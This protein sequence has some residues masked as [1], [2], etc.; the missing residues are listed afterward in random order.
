MSLPLALYYL[1]LQSLQFVQASPISPLNRRDAS[2]C[3]E[4]QDTR[5]ISSIIWSCLATVFL[6]TWVAIHPN[7]PPPEKSIVT[8]LRRVGI[9]AMAVI[10][11]ELVIMWAM[12]QWLVSRKLRKKYENMGW[13]QTH[14]FFALMGGFMLYEGDQPIRT[15][16]PDELEL[17]FLAGQIDFPH[18]TEEEIKD[19]SKGD[20][21]SKGLVIV[22]TGWFIMQCVARGVEHLPI[23]KLELSTLAFAVLNLATYALWW[24]KPLNVKRPFRVYQDK[25]SDTQSILLYGES[26]SESEGGRQPSVV[27][28]ILG[29]ITAP[30][31]PFAHMA[32]P[33]D[34]RPGAKT[35]P[36]FYAGS[37][38]KSELWMVILAAGTVAIAFGAIHCVAWSFQFPSHTERLIWRVSSFIIM[39]LPVAILVLHTDHR[40]HETPLILQAGA[41]ETPVRH[42]VNAAV[43][44][45]ITY[46]IARVALMVLAFMSMRV[47]PPQEYQIVHWT[48]IIPHI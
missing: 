34:I 45:F 6:C 3:D 29:V 24:N 43:F 14:G 38:A 40:T 20:F 25:L 39:G 33:P 44:V 42:K 4:S 18:I 27:H 21:V 31:A 13:T 48:N 22:Q 32:H 8:T 19:R 16:L 1:T 10:S 46:F 17:L 37:L 12:R 28:R 35:L 26:E 5:S 36:A 2:S 7:I 47:L 9:M 41:A 23:T 30:M 11:P 15:L